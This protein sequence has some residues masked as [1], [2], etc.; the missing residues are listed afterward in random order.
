MFQTMMSK[1][2]GYQNSGYKLFDAGF[3][4]L[5]RLEEGRLTEW[6][7]QERRRLYDA[8]RSGFDSLQD[9]LEAAQK[10]VS[11]KASFSEMEV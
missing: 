9:E 6:P 11:T 1:Q 8:Y 7:E 3:T 4:S 10:N 2:P 5:V